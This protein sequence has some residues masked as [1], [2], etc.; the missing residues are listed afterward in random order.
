MKLSAIFSPIHQ[1]HQQLVCPA[2]LRWTSKVGQLA[3]QYSHHFLEGLMLYSCQ[4]LEVSI[5]S[6]FYFFVFH[7]PIMAHL[8]L[9]QEV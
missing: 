2:Q 7:V 9:M 8:S 4:P 5:G 3:F 6:V 1:G